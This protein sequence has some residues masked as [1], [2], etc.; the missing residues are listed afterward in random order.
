MECLQRT[1]A[2][3]QEADTEISLVALLAFLLQVHGKLSGDDSFDIVGLR[4]CL[5]LHIIVQHHQNML[6]IG[7]GKLVVLHL[8][9]A[10]GL[11]VAAQKGLQHDAH[12]GLA[13][14]TLANEKEHLLGLG[15]GDQTVAEELLQGGDVLRVQQL[16][17]E[18]Q[19]CFRWGRIGV[20]CHRQAIATVVL[21]RG[22]AAV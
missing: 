4:E 7:T 19:P 20:V 21:F 2:K 22:K 10:A 13:L 16:G 8:C 5:H 12:P 9:D 1:V 17:E 6:Q 14:A 3:G 11:H 18:I 15:G